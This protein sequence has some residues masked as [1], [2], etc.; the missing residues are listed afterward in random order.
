MSNSALRRIKSQLVLA[1]HDL[2]QRRRWLF[3]NLSVSKISNLVIAVLQALCRLGHVRGYPPILKIDITPLC[4]LH[5]PICIHASPVPDSAPEL[6]KQRF[7]SDQM[8]TV[9]NFEKIVSEVQAKTIALSLYYF[10]DPLLHPKLAQLCS[11]ASQSGLSTHVSSNFSVRLSDEQL[12][13]LALSGLT[14]LTVCIDGFSQKSYEKTRVGGNLELVLNN[15]RRII[16]IR[17]D[18]MRKWPLVQ[19]KYLTYPHNLHEL[20]MAQSYFRSIGVDYVAVLPGDTINWADAVPGTEEIRG[21]KKTGGFFSCPMLYLTMV[22]KYDGNVVPCCKHR[23][24][25]QY[26]SGDART[27]GNVFQQGVKAVWNAPAYVANRRLAAFPSSASAEASARALFCYRCRNL[28][29]F[30]NESR[31]YF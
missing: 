15:L 30:Q 4:N 3:V 24:S 5:C 19:V 8:M 21:A 10:G 27:L 18:H 16:R 1:Y 25:A 11:I 6:K 2:I 17:N 14:H 7:S 9:E 28:F 20:P 22:I 31:P 12:R 29:E 13:D 23:V 26:S